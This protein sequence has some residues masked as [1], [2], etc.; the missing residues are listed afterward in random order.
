MPGSQIF[1][2][3]VSPMIRAPSAPHRARS[4]AS[5]C[6]TVMIW[7]PLPPESASQDGTGTG[8]TWVT[9]SKARSNGRSSLP[10][11]IR[12]PAR[13]ATWWISLARQA[14]SGA[15]GA[16]SLPLVSAIR[17]S[18]PAAARNSSMSRPPPGAGRTAAA[19]A[20]S[21]RNARARLIVI[22]I[23]WAVLLAS[24]RSSASWLAHCHPV[25]VPALARIVS[26]STSPVALI[27]RDTARRSSSA[28]A[29]AW[30]KA[31]K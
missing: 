27:Q 4:W 16:S 31:R 15:T 18:V 25:S 5:P 14:N 23:V 24:P 2:P 21:A 9:S 11:G 3:E 19:R 28:S 13:A 30:K 7:M 10:P 20:G 8:Q 26:A 22:R 1:A 6:A 17:Y 12:L 29:A